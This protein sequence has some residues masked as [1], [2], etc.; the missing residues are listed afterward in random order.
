VLNESAPLAQTQ[1]YINDRAQFERVAVERTRQHAQSDE[2]QG[3]EP[4]AEEKAPLPVPESAGARPSA[5]ASALV[6][7]AQGSTTG[8][9]GTM[10]PEDDSTDETSTKRI[11]LT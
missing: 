8:A 2:A 4:P 11:R 10:L 1:Q 7:G 3:A 5:G 6:I 9:Q